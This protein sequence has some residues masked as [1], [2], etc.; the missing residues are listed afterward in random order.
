MG[1]VE[2][3]V[4]A[5]PGER[6]KVAAVTAIADLRR[7]GQVRLID[8]LVVTKTAAGEVWSSELV[9]YEEYEEA[10]AEIGPEANLLGP[11]DAAEVGATL[12]PDSCAL[13]LLV[14]H[15][16]AARAAEVIR[17]ADGY[18]AGRVPIPHAFVEQA[19]A[20]YRE[21]VAEAASGRS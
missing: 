1:P 16:W 10:V 8:S 14:E 4:L 9:E 13:M 2:C 7:A 11:E 12:E 5:F 3:L 18:V 21:A 6:L 20:A 19:R 15:V 17:E